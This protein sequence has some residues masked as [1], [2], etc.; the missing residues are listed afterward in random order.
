MPASCRLRYT[1]STRGSGQTAL[2]HNRQKGA[3]QIPAVIQRVHAFLYIRSTRCLNRF[4]LE[5]ARLHIRF[6]SMASHDE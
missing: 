1:D 6:Q 3:I 5:W 2:P 4:L